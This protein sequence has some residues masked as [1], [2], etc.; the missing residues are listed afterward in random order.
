MRK[1][2][3]C[4]TVLGAVVTACS[5]AGG[6]DPDAISGPELAAVRRALDSARA[7]DPVVGRGI[8]VPRRSGEKARLDVEVE[9]GV[10]FRWGSHSDRLTLGNELPRKRLTA[11]SIRYES[12]LARDVEGVLVGRRETNGARTHHSA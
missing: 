1:L 12:R 8:T 6:V 11:I 4:L 7:P 10:I 3:L 5:D 2:I 9:Q